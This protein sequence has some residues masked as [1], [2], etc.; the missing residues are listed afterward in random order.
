MSAGKLDQ[1]LD[2]ILSKQRSGKVAAGRRKSTRRSTGP[3]KAA[4]AG[5]IQKAAKPVRGNAAKAVPA[6][7]A[8]K[9]GDSKIVVSN[10]V[11]TSL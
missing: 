3:V 1:S 2:E 4:P 10:L 5:G 8:G 6:K 7:T 11:S 9:P